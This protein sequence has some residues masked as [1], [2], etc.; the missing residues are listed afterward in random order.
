MN[1]HSKIKLCV[2]T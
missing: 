1:I 2:G